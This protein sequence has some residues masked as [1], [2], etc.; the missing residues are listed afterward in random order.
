M[1]KSL[2]STG[3]PLGP[4]DLIRNFV[5]MH[6]APDEQEE[7]DRDLWGPLEDRFARSDGTLDEERFSGFFRDYLMSAGRYVAPKN[8]FS[9]FEPRYDATGFSPNDLALGLTASVQ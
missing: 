7:F 5:F 8:T 2:S 3:V 9:N 1:F 6:V 4:S